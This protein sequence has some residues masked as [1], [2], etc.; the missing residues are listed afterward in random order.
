MDILIG[1][2]IFIAGIVLGIFLSR[3]IVKRE[4]MKNPPISEE[5]I[6]AMLKGMGQAPT[7]KRV[8]SIMK[9]MKAANQK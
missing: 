3:F 2:L 5:M 4:L 1:I 9:Q 6:A 7:K 8:N